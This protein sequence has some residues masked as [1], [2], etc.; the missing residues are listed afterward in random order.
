MIPSSSTVATRLA[1][2]LNPALPSGVHQKALEVYSSVFSII[3][4][5]GLGRDLHLYF[6]GLS[7]VLSFASL[8]VRPLFLSLIETHVLNLPTTALRPATKAIILALLPGLEDETSEDF[9]RMVSALDK[10][11]KSIRSEQGHDLGTKNEAP[12]SYFWQCF[13]LA[14]VT[15]SSRRQGALSYL[16]RRLPS[17]SSKT[18]KGSA[19]TV[20][21]DDPFVTAQSIITPEPGLLIRCFASGLADSQLLIQRG[22]LD[23]L[24][25][26]IPLDSTVLQ[27]KVTESDLDRLIS[28]A[29][30]VVIRRDMSLNRRLWAWFLGPESSTGHEEGEH[31]DQGSSHQALFF[32][33]F[34]LKPLTRSMLRLIRGNSVL[35]A[36]RARPFRVCLSLMDR[37]EVGG[38]IVPEIFVPALEYVERYSHT[39]TKEQLDEVVRS[40]SLFFDGVESSLIFGKLLELAMS[41]LTND[42]LPNH[43]KLRQLKLIKFVLSRFNVKEDEM[44][45]DHM[46]LVSLAIVAVL[47][48][49][50]KKYVFNSPEYHSRTPTFSMISRNAPSADLTSSS[51]SIEDEVLHLALNITET[52]IS[53]IPDRAFTTTE[54]QKITQATVPT[55]DVLR[56]IS[57][58]YSDSNSSQEVIN[59]PFSPQKLS[60]L[61][62]YHVAALFCSLLSD[63]GKVAFAETTSR[64]L[65]NMLFKVPS[66]EGLQ[67]LDI[68]RSFSDA[69]VN[70]HN[71]QDIPSFQIAVSITTVLA[72]LQSAQQSNPY[73]DS[74]V[75]PH[76]V[77]SMVELLWEYLSP[78][79]PKYHVEAVRCLLQLHAIT[80][81]N[82]L[83]EASVTALLNSAEST[84]DADERVNSV[85]AG[86][87]LAV[88]WTHTIHEQSLQTEK[89]ARPV[90]R[91]HSLLTADL[92]SSE[93][94]YEALLTRPLFH[95][96]DALSQDGSELFTFV[97]AWLQDLPTLNRVFH[98]L[99][100]HLRSLKVLL[101][102][103]ATLDAAVSRSQEASLAADDAAE[104]V[105][106]LRHVLNILRWASDYTWITLAEEAV[107]PLEDTQPNSE[108]NVPLQLLL[109]QIC[110]RAI[111]YQNTA[112]TT[113]RY[114]KLHFVKD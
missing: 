69:L 76:I 39:A 93:G 12:D 50:R 13:F 57:K 27:N 56:S 42:A 104:G 33:R 80:A 16:V 87:R 70:R 30:G 31:G 107:F 62:T 53:T 77:K 101:P 84:P 52:L 94:G 11:Q 97:K 15:N 55:D 44:L 25:S 41:A 90:S 46:P 86:G 95:M 114:A 98:I 18:G 14:V 106:F 111:N 60:V 20:L 7:T 43:E 105:Y 47:Q 66:F 61:L 96:L 54:P 65:S 58:F 17:L 100:T 48:A 6:P 79:K 51:N 34:G 92:T 45:L 3:G 82:R 4:K 63:N 10:L 5:A 35:P 38:L 21:G 99:I 68:V 102:K 22:F 2:C 81:S 9:E 113:N 32:S 23:L 91:R 24:V 1:Q 71:P 29:A 78:S 109:A 103:R 49:Q 40:A 64:I 83:I 67:E 59:T 85:E 36:E 72:P 73:I 74:S 28:A 108:R 19:D 88:L 75:I 37:W 8:T 112:K 26:H 110:L 89:G